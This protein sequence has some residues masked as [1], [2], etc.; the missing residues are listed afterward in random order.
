MLE[1]VIKVLD[2]TE[3]PADVA[4]IELV[5]ICDPDPLRAAA[6]AKE[7]TCRSAIYVGKASDPAAEQFAA[8]LSAARP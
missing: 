8:E 4:G 1:S 7:L 5:V 6:A 3:T 2:A